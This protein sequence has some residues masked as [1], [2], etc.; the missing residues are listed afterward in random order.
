MK[1]V[2]TQGRDH[3][4]GDADGYMPAHLSEDIGFVPTIPP[5]GTEGRE[6]DLWPKGQTANVVRALTLVPDAL[7]DWRDLGDAQYLSFQ[8][9][10]NFEQPANR[11]I[12]RMQIELVAGRISAVNECF[13]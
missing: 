8:E 13:Y 10:Q 5:D 6:A 11:S 7:R 2:D 1:L 3:E 4:P 9:M 12:N